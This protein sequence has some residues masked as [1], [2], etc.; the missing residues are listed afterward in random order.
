MTLNTEYQ[1]DVIPLTKTWNSDNNP[2]FVA[3]VL[4]GYQKYEST[5]DSTKK[6]G[7]GLHVKISYCHIH[8]KN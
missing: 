7:Y 6:G 8:F 4:P 5:S 2:S 3:G 1:F